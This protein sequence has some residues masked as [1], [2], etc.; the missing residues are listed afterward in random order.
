MAREKRRLEAEK[1]KEVLAKRSEEEEARRK[2]EIAAAASMDV[3]ED[4]PPI[5]IT[6]KEKWL[7]ERPFKPIPQRQEHYNQKSLLYEEAVEVICLIPS[8]L[9]SCRPH[10]VS[11]FP[12]PA[13]VFENKRGD[14][15]TRLDEQLVGELR[16]FGF[17]SDTEGISDTIHQAAMT[18]LE[19]QHKQ[20]ASVL[21]ANQKKSLEYERGAIVWH[22]QRAVRERDI[23]IIESHFDEE[24][25]KSTSHSGGSERAESPFTDDEQEEDDELTTQLLHKDL[26]EKEIKES[27]TPV[28]PQ[29]EEQRYDRGQHYKADDR[30][31]GAAA[32]NPTA[33]NQP[34]VSQS[35]NESKA[36]KKHGNYNANSYSRKQMNRFKI[37]TQESTDGVPNSSEQFTGNRTVITKYVPPW[38]QQ[39]LVVKKDAAK[40]GVEGENEAEFGLGQ[41]ESDEEMENQVVRYV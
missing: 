16:K 3:G 6:E 8:P 2:L 19:K 5:P 27:R 22:T 15:V 29:I 11:K 25:D 24:S 37:Q 1:E 35:N 23:Q 34:S 21:Q 31:N 36:E 30:Y 12:H 9:Y 40:E 20:R 38:G 39:E 10:I 14:L 4:G 18:A 28:T 7:Q 41:W 33:E 13:N 17:S 32:L 26:K